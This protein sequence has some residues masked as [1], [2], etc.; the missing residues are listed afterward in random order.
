MLHDLKAVVGK[1]VD[2]DILFEVLDIDF[3]FEE[4][5]E[6]FLFGVAVII[7]SF[8]PADGRVVEVP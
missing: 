4:V 8:D 1:A 6:A 5:T 3:H 2:L 7:D